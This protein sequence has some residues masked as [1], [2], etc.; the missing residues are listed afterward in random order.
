MDV[1]VE[2]LGEHGGD[3]LQHTFAVDAFQ[4]EGVDDVALCDD[5]FLLAAHKRHIPAPTLLTEFVVS[6][7]RTIEYAVQVALVEGDVSVSNLHEH[8]FVRLALVTLTQTVESQGSDRHAILL[9]P[10]LQY[11]FS[12]T[13]LF[14]FALAKQSLN[15]VAS[16]CRGDVVEP[17]WM[18]MLR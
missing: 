13:G 17:F 10:C 4:G 16:L 14:A 9:Q 15:L 11:L 12:G 3:I 8:A 2:L 1:D 7:L 6:V 18:H 5:V